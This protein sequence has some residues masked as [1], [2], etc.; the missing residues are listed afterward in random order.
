[1]KQKPDF[2]GGGGGEAVDLTPKA[3]PMDKIMP[4]KHEQTTTKL[5]RLDA[6]QR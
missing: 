1:M 2:G 4:M 6:V 5:S 3:L